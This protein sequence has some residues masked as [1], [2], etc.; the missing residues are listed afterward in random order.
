MMTEITVVDVIPEQQV[1]QP[2]STPTLPNPPT[3]G[4]QPQT[5]PQPPTPPTSTH[6]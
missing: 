3:Q 4:T 6:P 1:M 2:Y 5:S